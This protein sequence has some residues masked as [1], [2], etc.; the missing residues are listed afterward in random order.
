MI[1]KTS[2]YALIDPRDEEFNPRYIG[3][4]SQDLNKRLADHLKLNSKKNHNTHR[5]N[6][7]RKLKNDG[8]RVEIILLDSVDSFEEALEIEIELIGYYRSHG[9]NLTNITMGGDGAPGYKHTEETKAIMKEKRKLQ[10]YS[11]ETRRKI[12]AFQKSKRLSEE[13]KRR[14]SDGW[15]LRRLANPTM[16]TETREKISESLKKFYINKKNALND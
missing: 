2:I 9:Y 14:I 10:T 7:V 1:K 6:W 11:D 4:T 8:V 16:S 5:E 13:T 15:K 3:V 12:S